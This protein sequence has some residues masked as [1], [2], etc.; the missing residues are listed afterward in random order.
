MVTLTIDGTDRTGDTDTGARI[1]VGRSTVRDQGAPGYVSATVC[2]ARRDMLLSAGAAVEVTAA[3]RIRHRGTITDIG[4][5]H[6][7]PSDTGRLAVQPVTAMGPLASWGRRFIGDQPWPVES[8]AD[9]ARRI[10]ALAGSPITVHGGAQLVT[11]RDVDRRRAGELLAELADSTGGWLYDQAG[12][13]HLQALD[14][15][16]VTPA[17]VRWS[18]EPAAASWADLDGSPWHDDDSGTIAPAIVIPCTAIDWQPSWQQSSEVTNRVRIEYGPAP[19]EGER[20]VVEVSSPESIAVHGES[21]TRISTVLQ[22]RADALTLA[23]LILDR[24]A[25][26]QWRLSTVVVP[27]DEAPAQL[28]AQ[29][30]TMAPG[31]RA[32][33]TGIPQPAPA[34]SFPGVVEGWSETLSWDPDTGGT[35][36]TFTIA[37]SHA[38]HSLALPSWDAQPPAAR[39]SDL[40]PYA[41][42]EEDL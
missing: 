30:D 15:R 21:E 41:R 32:T 9:R 20:P 29:L 38:A 7:A 26:P 40:D 2:T 14:A 25:W 39:W 31:A 35:R 34:A 5:T 11:A 8:V 36:R 4:L 22:E 24:A 27:Y 37:L 19:A 12:T 13:V 28:R 3:G 23:G 42:W 16:R 17:T 1:V 33:V 10:A 18:D 6:E